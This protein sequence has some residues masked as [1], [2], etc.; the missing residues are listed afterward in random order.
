MKCEIADRKTRY[1]PPQRYRAR[2]WSLAT[3]EPSREGERAKPTAPGLRK[4]DRP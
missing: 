2:H 3:A 1:R 4:I